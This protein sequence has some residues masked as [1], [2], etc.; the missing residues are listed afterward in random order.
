MLRAQRIYHQRFPNRRLPDRKTFESLH[1]RLRETGSVVRTRPE[2]ALPRA[3]RTPAKEDTI[4]DAITEQPQ[5]S[6]RQLSRILHVSHS[7]V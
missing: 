1:R 7:T 3:V 6:T 5:A 2:I 4:L